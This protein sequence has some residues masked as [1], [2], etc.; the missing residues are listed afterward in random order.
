VAVERRL[1]KPVPLHF[2]QRLAQ[3]E[4][5]PEPFARLRVHFRR[6]KNGGWPAVQELCRLESGNRGE[7]RSHR[8]DPMFG[9]Y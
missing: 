5:D 2:F 4:L 7:A 8:H 1:I 3:I 9:I 6:E